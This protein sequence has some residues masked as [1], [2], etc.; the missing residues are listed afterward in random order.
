[1]PGLR[2][3]G[4]AAD[5]TSVDASFDDISTLARGCRF[6]DCRHTTEPGCAVTA[7]ITSGEMDSSRLASYQKLRRE[8]AFESRRHDPLARAAE[9]RIWKMRTKEFRRRGR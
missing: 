3:L 5:G 7:A 9:L 4:L 6:S 2:S 8:V 1:M